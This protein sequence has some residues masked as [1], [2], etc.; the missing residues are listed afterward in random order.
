MANNAQQALFSRRRRAR[1]M[2][3]DTFGCLPSMPSWLRYTY[4]IQHI[5][6]AKVKCESG[7]Q[8]FEEED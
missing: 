7:R 6:I 1:G 2:Y 5:G 4:L 3:V 8:L